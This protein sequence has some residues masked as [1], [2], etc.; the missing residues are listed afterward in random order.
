MPIRVVLEAQD[1]TKVIELPEVQIPLGADGSSFGN[2]NMLA[3]K[4]QSPGR[5]SVVVT[6][7]DAVLATKTLK[8]LRVEAKAAAH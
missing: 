5:Y 3:V 7:R 6:T 8:V 1:G 4:L 2:V